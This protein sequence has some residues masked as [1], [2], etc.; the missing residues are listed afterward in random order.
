MPTIE[1]ELVRVPTKT[2]ISIA[3]EPV[4][5]LF[6]SLM[7][8][9]KSE[10]LSGL[11][12]WISQT[13]ARLSPEQ[14]H[15]HALVIQGL[16]FAIRPQRSWS[17]FPAYLDYITAQDPQV[18]RDRIISAYIYHSCLVDE[19]ILRP[20]EPDE[21][22]ATLDSFLSLLRAGFPPEAIDEKLETE[23]YAL[24]KDPPAMKALI[25][26][27]LQFMWTEFLAEEW[28]RQEPMLQTSVEAF[29]QLDFSGLTILEIAEKIVGQ[30]L[31]EKWV[32]L[33]GQELDR[34]TFVPSAHLGPYLGIYRTNG[35]VWLLFGAR[36]PE[37]SLI[38]SPD[39]SRS[40][41]LVRLNALADDTRLHILQS[42]HEAGEL[43]SKTIMDQLDLS[44]SAASRHLKQLSATGYLTER[45]QN[46]AKCYRLNEERIENTIHALSHFLLG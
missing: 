7:W 38:S 42:L 11:H 22:L 37:G 45:R 17:S 46:G 1:A 20:D 31:P 19:T 44:Q 30:E 9:R 16:H 18:L 41:I 13:E 12:D 8:I 15:T 6:N 14:R 25:V 39:L 4:Q 10:H 3:L 21:V 35:N 24:L 43:C 23:A 33:L 5:Q 40:E 32:E 29:Q 26:S 28:K 2:K 27:H 36:L 34:I